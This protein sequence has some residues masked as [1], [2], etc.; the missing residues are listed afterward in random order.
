LEKKLDPVTRLDPEKALD[1]PYRTR[2]GRG[3]QGALPALPEHV[4]KSATVEVDQLEGAEW[5]KVS[6]QWPVEQ[7][8]AI[9]KEGCS[10]G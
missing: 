10:E 9:Q 2:G 8:A 7:G 1:P 3:H 4:T 6:N 5:V